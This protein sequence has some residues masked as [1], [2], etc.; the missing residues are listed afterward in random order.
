[1]EEDAFY[2]DFQNEKIHAHCAAR[3]ITARSP[4]RRKDDDM[5]EL[6]DI[7]TACALQSRHDRLVA[8]YRN[9]PEAQEAI[10]LELAE[11]DTAIGKLYSPC[12]AA[13]DMAADGHET[14]MQIRASL[15]L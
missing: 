3:D 12:P 7:E 1:L 15:G 11:L 5:P 10:S 8:E 9:R 13:Y 14:P 4:V 2:V 6:D